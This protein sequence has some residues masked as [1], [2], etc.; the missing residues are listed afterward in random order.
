MTNPWQT[1]RSFMSVLTT[2]AGVTAVQAAGTQ[3]AAQV[4]AGSAQNLGLAVD[5]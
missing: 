1:R 2:L 5:R 3:V 4:P